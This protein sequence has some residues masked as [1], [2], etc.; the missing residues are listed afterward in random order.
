[1]QLNHSRKGSQG[2][3]FSEWNWIQ[4]Q[5][6]QQKHPAQHKITVI[7]QEEYSQ[8]LGLE[9]LFSAFTGNKPSKT[10]VRRHR[11]TYSRP[12]SNRQ[13]LS[14]SESRVQLNHSRKGSQ[15]KKF[16]EWNW[17]QEQNHQQK[18]P[19][20]HKITVINQEEYSQTLGLEK[21]FSAFS[22][23]ERATV[24]NIIDHHQNTVSAFDV[25]RSI[26]STG[27]KEFNLP[28]TTD[29][30]IHSENIWPFLRSS[31]EEDWETVSN[32]SNDSWEVLSIHSVESDWSLISS[33]EKDIGSKMQ[34]HSSALEKEKSYAQATK[35]SC[36]RKVQAQDQEVSLT[37]ALTA[38]NHSTAVVNPKKCTE[39]PDDVDDDDFFEQAYFNLKLPGQRRYGKLKKEKFSRVIP[40][41]SKSRR[42]TDKEHISRGQRIY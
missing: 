16:S 12:T 40:K 8:T 28:D 26:V 42:K 9:K 27:I 22:H 4:E 36:L 14:T 41:S 5:N 6:H 20:Q 35:L 32:T 34:Q 38:F 21:L 33:N 7:N 37:S 1:V 18:H 39:Y 29:L 30:S 13:P 11:R 19:A 10:G 23:L 3:K 25:I 17:I 15:G 31:C 2:K 24:Q